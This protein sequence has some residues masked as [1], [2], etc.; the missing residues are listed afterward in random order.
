MPF[1]KAYLDKVSLDPHLAGRHSRS[2]LSL[3]VAIPA[4]DEPGVLQTLHSLRSCTPPRGAVEVIVALN[5]CEDDP[6]EVLENNRSTEREIRGFIR[7]HTDP[8]F[9][10]MF[11]HMSGISRK[12]AGAGLARKLAMDH[13]LSRF[14]GLDRPDG[15]IV[16]LDAD[17]V[18]DPDYLLEIEDHFRSDPASLACSVYFEHPIRGSHFPE[19]AYRGIAQYELHLRYYIQGLRYAGHP[20]AYHTIGS[21]FCVRAG[22]YAAQGGMNR[23]KAGEDFYFLQKLI[24]LGDFHDLNTTCV[25]P[26]PRPS[27]RVAFGTGPVIGRFLSGEIDSL[28]SYHPRSF[29]D[30]K[31]FIQDV[32]KLYGASADEI[33]G[34]YRSWPQ[35]IRENLE[36]EFTSRLEEIRGNAA[37]E[38]S[39]YKRFF[40]WFNRFRTLKFMHYARREFY[41]PM[42]VRQAAAEFLDGRGKKGLRDASAGDLLMIL[43]KIQREGV[44]TL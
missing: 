16:S 37:G 17:T 28:E 44:W 41:P 6:E 2:D 13:A 35:T 34:L 38:K 4:R 7:E 33:H 25:Y 11:T 24:Q 39:F 22:V 19:Q 43:R 31:A 9:S 18:C 40:R 15:I 20:Q 27:R 1:A 14:D 23:R 29:D 30:L 8:A 5:S 26:S 12:H 21:A 10:L 36:G 42:P 32:P 3:V